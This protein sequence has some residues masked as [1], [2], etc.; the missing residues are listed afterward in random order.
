[1]S[2]GE[3]E[4]Y[5]LDIDNEP[6]WRDSVDRDIFRKMFD[7]YLNVFLCNLCNAW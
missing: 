3:I 4:N 5:L 1:M 6:K 2:R 7:I